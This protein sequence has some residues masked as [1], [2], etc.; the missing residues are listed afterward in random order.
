MSG[1]L[2][3]DGSAGHDLGNAEHHDQGEKQQIDI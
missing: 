2:A 3:P 1:G